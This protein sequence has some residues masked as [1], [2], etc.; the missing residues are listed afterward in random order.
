MSLTLPH[1]PY[2]VLDATLPR[3]ATLIEAFR[4]TVDTASPRRH[5]LDLAAQLAV[6]HRQQWHAEDVCRRSQASETDIAAAKRLIDHLNGV[7]V[8]LVG[9]IDEGLIRGIRF[10]GAAPLHTETLGSVI[11][12]LAIAW[13]RS[14]VMAS[15]WE[16][17]DRARAAL[18][19]LAELAHAY[20]DLVREVAAGH[21]R[22][23]AWRP[24]KDYGAA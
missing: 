14:N 16:G 17:R 1:Q 24:L 10:P 8:H 18:A 11:D 2:T 12:R 7:R 21:R 6:N 20:D 22:L 9:R 19:Q 4:G 5:V 13:V 15:R 23:P 3:S